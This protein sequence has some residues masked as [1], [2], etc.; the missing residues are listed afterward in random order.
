[1]SQ[2]AYRDV[3]KMQ[4]FNENDQNAAITEYL[5]NG[6]VNLDPSVTAWCAGIVNAGLEQQGISGTGKLNARSF[7]EWGEDAGEGA[8]GD[9]AVF[10]RGDPNGW[11]GHVG[12]YT[13]RNDENGNP[14]IMG[15][16]QGDSIS[17]RAYDKSR[18]LGYRRSGGSHHGSVTG[19][20]YG[21]KEKGKNAGLGDRWSRKRDDEAYVEDRSRFEGKLGTALGLNEGGLRDKMLGKMGLDSAGGH[22]L[23]SALAGLGQSNFGGGF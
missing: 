5:K 20:E 21:S 1:M 12:F 7:M 3:A 10:S 22:R 8:E 4:G 2:A 19:S 18:L 14:I 17:E 15:G 23:G 13:G 6:G 11:Q 16:N 9:I